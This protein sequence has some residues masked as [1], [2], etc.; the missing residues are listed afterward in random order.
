MQRPLALALLGAVVASC[1]LVACSDEDTTDT[2]PPP[3]PGASTGLGAWGS[4][5][6]SVGPVTSSRPRSPAT[7]TVK[8]T[9][10]AS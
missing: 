1:V 9:A 6:S 5:G 10:T 8:V 2:K 4:G 7:V 3:R